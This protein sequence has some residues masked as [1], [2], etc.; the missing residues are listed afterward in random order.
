M[1]RVVYSLRPGYA[2]LACWTQESGIRSS[3]RAAAAAAQT[4]KAVEPPHEHQT[5]PE[6]KSPLGDTCKAQSSAASSAGSTSR[7]RPWTGSADKREIEKFD[8]L[9][10]EWWN[11]RGPFGTLHALN[12]AR[13]HFLRDAVS[14]HFGRDRH[15]LYPCHQLSIVDVGC[16]GGVLSEPM[17]RLGGHLLGID[18]AHQNITAA[19]AH[20][21]QDPSL[22]ESLRYEVTSAEALVKQ[23]QQYDI[24]VCSEVIEHVQAPAEF[25]KTL[26][27]LRKPHGCIIVTTINRT[28]EAF[29]L[30]IVAAE[31]ILGMAPDGA[32]DWSKFVT[33]EEL[34]LVFG[35][36]GLNMHLLCG[37]QLDL[38]G[39]RWKCTENTSVNYAAMFAK[40]VR[41]L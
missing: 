21:Q 39:G 1:F 28:P 32:H 25:C 11:P 4:L 17:A 29:A 14:Q 24:V 3:A 34:Q 27:D 36:V 2:A 40:G 18:V 16:G 15:G 6:A 38:L 35:E 12:T 33:P 20:A 5:T 41:V 13:V 23:G 9:A 31:K 22:Q 10:E 19:R 30:A 7:Q 8:K 26:A 37:M